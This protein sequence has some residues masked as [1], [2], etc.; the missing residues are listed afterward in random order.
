MR[1]GDS[2]TFVSVG[3]ESNLVDAMRDSIGVVPG[4]AVEFTTPQFTRPAGEPVPSTPSRDP[5][6]WESLC[7]MGLVALKEMGLG[8][9]AKEHG[10][11]LML[12]PG[13]WYDYIPMGYRVLDICAFDFCRFDSTMNGGTYLAYR[14]SIILVT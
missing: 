14:F 5:A 13:E 2:M 12:F 11:A 9:W 6:W 4:E 7:S 10:R 8:V 1:N 3:G